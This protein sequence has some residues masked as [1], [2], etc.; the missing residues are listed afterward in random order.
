M[1]PEVVK[2]ANESLRQ[3]ANH[4]SLA[5]FE[6]NRLLFLGDTENFQIKQIAEDLK[7][8]GRENFYI[9]ITPPSACPAE[10]GPGKML[11][12]GL[13]ERGLSYGQ[14]NSTPALG[15]PGRHRSIGFFEPLGLNA[16]R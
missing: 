1:R 9:F 2:E 14:E 7:S 15:H 11:D 3:A 4:L 5:L 16:Y 6:D 13:K 8:K 10:I 12:T